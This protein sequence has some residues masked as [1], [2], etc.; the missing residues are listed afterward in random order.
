MLDLYSAELR[1]FRK[2][3]AAFAAANLLA[4]AL[5]QQLVEI[6]TGPQSMHLVLLFFYTLAGC[7]FA[8]FQFGSYRHPSRWI[9][10]LHRP[11]HRARI[12]AALVLAALTMT[13][14]AVALPMM[15]VLVGQARLTPRVIDARHYAGAACLALAAL[16]GWLAGGW[17]MLHRSRWTF[18]VALFPLVLCVQF[19]TARTALGLWLA[20]DAM[21]LVLLYTA[22]SPSRA[23]SAGAPAA[24]P[25]AIVLS[26]CMYLAL[27]W[28]G[29]VLY[30]VRQVLPGLAVPVTG[31]GYRATFRLTA[32]E[33]VLA[34]LQGSTE[35]AAWRSALPGASAQIVGPAIR[36]IPVP[37]MV[38]NFGQVLFVLGE[39]KWTFSADA[40]RY[41]G[42]NMRTQNGA[43]WFGPVGGFSAQPIA[44]GD[45]HGGKWLVDAHA[46]YALDDAAPS[47]RKVLQV[48]P[49]EWLAGGVVWAGQQR[50]LLTNR[51]VLL[52]KP[53]GAGLAIER[54]IALPA[55]FGDVALVDAAQVADGTLVSVLS[56]Y[57]HD[58][59]AA[60]PRQI[61]YL[62]AHDGAVR[63]VARR[64][65]PHD[66]V[67]LFEHRAWWASP[68]L[69]AIVSLPDLLID[70][71]NLPDDRAGA[72]APLI[73]PRPASAWIAAIVAMLL[74]GAGAAWWTRRAGIAPGARLA[75]CLACLALGMPALLVLAILAP[76]PARARRFLPV[77]LKANR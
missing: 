28:S 54:A 58:D 17:F 48:D 16:T 40:L 69:H 14:L 45:T 68:V 33:R 44:R 77:N 34:G 74:A 10:L 56:G 72:L 6:T 76:L 18:L 73:L 27:L 57:R 32:P 51:R 11:L 52:L 46:L 53:A 39:T 20:C 3:A 59:G 49:G 24:L 55:A 75:W 19:A 12:L 62:A 41:R 66:Y 42:V 1:R 8:A 37:D 30:Q 60:P 38:S 47:V 7:A 50:L 9:W 43:G 25:G 63:E 64:D 4:L 26:V 21:L 70:H 61:V 22:F 31:D 5:L 36:A 67:A 23:T 35:A 65:M 29:S 13:V 15:I 2:S 71:G